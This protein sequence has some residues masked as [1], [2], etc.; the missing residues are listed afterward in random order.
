[1]KKI[2][3][4]AVLFIACLAGVQ[5]QTTLTGKVVTNKGA[6]KTADVSYPL[7]DIYELLGYANSAAVKTALDNK[8]IEITA[9]N[10]DGNAVGGTNVGEGTQFTSYYKRGDEEGKQ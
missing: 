4:T 2:L 9:I 6:W 3:L 10:T 7:N 1:M 8:E 5:A